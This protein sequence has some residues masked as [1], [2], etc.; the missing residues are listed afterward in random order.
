MVVHSSTYFSI[1]TIDTSIIFL[2]WIR[3]AFAPAQNSASMLSRNLASRPCTSCLLPPP[4]S[5]P[6]RHSRVRMEALA[7]TLLPQME[8]RPSTI[9]N[10]RFVC[11]LRARTEARRFKYRPTLAPARNRTRSMLQPI[12]W[13]VFYSLLETLANEHPPADVPLPSSHARTSIRKRSSIGLCRWLV[14]KVPFC[15]PSPSP[16]AAELDRPSAPDSTMHEDS[17][18]MRCISHLR[19]SLSILGALAR[20]FKQCAAR[21]AP[22]IFSQNLGLSG[23]RKLRKKPHMTT[24]VRSLKLAISVMGRG[25]ERRQRGYNGGACAGAA[26]RDPRDRSPAYLSTSKSKTKGDRGKE[27]T[28]TLS[29]DDSAVEYA[30]ES[31]S[32]GKSLL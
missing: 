8:C 31:P 7:M 17:Q 16:N 19:G 20:A 10:W 18:E 4:S 28:C 12:F 3:R 29:R 6:S 2:G 25:F 9:H 13:Q 32:R 15:A 1:V 21:F 5:I 24:P 26:T 30:V 14:S 22:H 27:V 23:I 11:M